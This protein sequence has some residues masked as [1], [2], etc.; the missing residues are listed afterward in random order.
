MFNAM[1]FLTSTTTNT[2][3]VTIVDSTF[4]GND[5]RYNTAIVSWSGA[6]LDLSGNTFDD[7]SV[8]NY[9]TITSKINVVVL[10]NGTVQIDGARVHHV[11]PDVWKL[12]IVTSI[13]HCDNSYLATGLDGNGLVAVRLVNE[14]VLGN[15]NTDAI[16]EVQMVAFA[17]DAK[18]YED[19]E[20]YKN[21]ASPSEKKETILMKDGL[22]V[23]TDFLINN[24]AHLTEEERS[25]KN[26]CFDNLVDVCGTITMCYKYPLEMFDSKLNSYYIANIITDFGELKIIIAQP[27]F[28][29]DLAGFGAGNVFVGKV[30]LSGDVC[31]YDYEKFVSELKKTAVKGCECNE[32][33]C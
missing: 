19:Y 6:T 32:E 29:K 3:D 10:D 25:A 31:I 7:N 22:A 24:S 2:I 13:S 26:H 17:V 30:M 28:P 23:A 5:D 14:H 1:T 18:I 4:T 16:I 27:L 33:D 12:K 20:A 8:I 9:G 15:I 11:S 21:S